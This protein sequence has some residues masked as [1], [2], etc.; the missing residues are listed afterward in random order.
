[1]SGNTNSRIFEIKVGASVS[2]SG[3]TLADGKLLSSGLGGCISNSGNLTI[4]GCTLS[5]NSSS[6]AYG[7]VIYNLAG[8]VTIRDSTMCSNRTFAAGGVLF[9]DGTAAIINCALFGN[10]GSQGAAL[11][12]QA[13]RSMLVTNCTIFGNAAADRGGGIY[14]A[15]SLTV[16]SCTIVSNSAAAV[17]GNG[18][19][20]GIAK[21]GT[22]FASIGNTIIANNTSATNQ[23]DCSGTNFTSAGYNLIGKSNGSTG[24]GSLGDQVGTIASPLNPMLGPLQNSGGAAA[25]LS[26]LP[27]SPAIDQG[28]SLGLTT[29]QRGRSRPA[30]YPSIPNA[31]GGDGTDIGAVEVWPESPQ[32]NIQRLSAAVVL[33]WSTNATDFRLQASTN[34]PPSNTWA[35]VSGAPGTIGSQF[36]VTNVVSDGS[37]LYRLIFP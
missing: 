1:V 24:W 13:G 36:C 34:Q 12:N 26:P 30:D 14:S 16:R 21:E 8:S 20:G 28:K 2:I 18:G 37:K 10:T 5:N 22:T 9:N 29:D 17:A 32:L 6:S 23:P 33:S 31:T 27:G 19:G 7:N 4:T 35:V 11:N 25:T 15:G 3:L